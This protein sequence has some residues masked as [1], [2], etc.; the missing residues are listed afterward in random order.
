MTAGRRAKAVALGLVALGVGVGAIAARPLPLQNGKPAEAAAEL[1][2]QAAIRGEQLRRRWELAAAESAFREA[3][4]LDPGN[5]ESRLGMAR[6]ARARFKYRD[7]LSSLEAAAP[8]HPNSASLLAEYGAMYL[9]AEETGRAKRYFDSALKTNPTLADAIVGRAV[10]DIFEREYQTAEARLRLLLKSDPTCSRAHVM[11]ARVLLERDQRKEA[12]AMA[13][14]ALALDPYDV[15][16]IY[17]LGF[18]KGVE[19]KPGEAR[20]HARRGLELDPLNPGLRRLLSAYVDGEAGYRQKVDEGAQQHFE[21]AS[22]LKRAGK[23]VE[24]AVEY[25]AA[26]DIERR[27]Y[28][29]LIGLGDLRLRL[30][31]H[32]GAAEAA[33][34]AL[35]VDPDGSLAHLQLSYACWGLQERARMEIGGRDFAEL[36]LEQQPPPV[37]ELTAELFPDYKSLTRRQQLVI[38]RAVAPIA[39][40]LPK[41]VAR[42][43]RHYLLPL[44]QSASE[45]AGLDERDEDRTFDGRY[46]SSLRGIGGQLTMSGIE[47]LETAA[48]GGVNVVAHELAH[49]VHLTALGP[50]ETKLIARLYRRALRERRTLD[51][52]SAANEFEYFAQGYEAFVSTC[53]RPAASV[54]GRHTIAELLR[55]DPQL[56]GFL[57]RLTGHLPAMSVCPI[58]FNSVLDS[59]AAF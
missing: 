17:V 15:D 38:D 11:L 23:L 30:R 24:A 7:A 21:R 1:A 4:A 40:L 12:A 49:Q 31:D 47:H 14:R 44:D 43:A 29:A 35:E 53:K 54:T 32:E 45:A 52:Y 34:L 27:Y 41:L 22:A 5:L 48:L 58:A 36:L 56:Y 46:Y 59:Y 26:L 8:H 33:R 39:R 57:T 51:Y 55:R 18:V 2:R 6:V 42:G 10:V 9:A 19:R 50:D 37:L 3:A 16:A 13:E 25:Q 28:R 20:S